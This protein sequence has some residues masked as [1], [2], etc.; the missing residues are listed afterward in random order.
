MSHNG[1][2]FRPIISF[3][4]DISF[5]TGIMSIAIRYESV[6]MVLLTYIPMT[7]GRKELTFTT[8]P[9]AGRWFVNA[10]GEFQLSFYIQ[11]WYK[12]LYVP[13]MI[14]VL[15]T[16]MIYYN[17]VQIPVP[18]YGVTSPISRLLN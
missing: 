14:Y 16:I 11:T 8:K 17:M 12:Y 15:K 4:V 1:E 3:S 2:S 13:T 7:F 10:H 9:A 18:S 6:A 5:T